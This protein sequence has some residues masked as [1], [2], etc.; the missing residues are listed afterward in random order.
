MTS[1]HAASVSLASQT[2]DDLGG[3]I[4]RMGH[5]TAPGVVELTK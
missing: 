4:G 5:A 1:P 2:V 3:L